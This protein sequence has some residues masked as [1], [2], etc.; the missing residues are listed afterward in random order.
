M[1]PDL[2][3]VSR[4]AQDVMLALGA[5]AIMIGLGTVGAGLA[6]VDHALTA[7]LL[8]SSPVGTG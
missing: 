6:T 2:R 7:V 4:G 3:A 1:M 5:A 8:Q